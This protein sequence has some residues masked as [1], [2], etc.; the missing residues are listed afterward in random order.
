V[1]SIG[2]SKDFRLV[3]G[4]LTEPEIYPLIGDDFSPPW[5]RFRVNEHP[6]IWYVAVHDAGRLIGMFSLV[7]QNR[8]C[9]ELHAVMLP[10]AGTVEKWR[11]A[12]ALPAWLAE[13]TECRRL[14]AAV[15]ACNGPAIA[16]GT[17]GIGMHYVGRQ[18]KAFQKNGQ[19]HDLV[20]L[21]RS[22]G[23]VKCQA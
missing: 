10:G 8:V 17:H 1:I 11:A 15:P 6:D 13:N 21:G 14:T 3:W 5:W 18:V 19:L 2:R 4:I 16:Y 9:W 12:R 7:P 22:I 20:L 23:E